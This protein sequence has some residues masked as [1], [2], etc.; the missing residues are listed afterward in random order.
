MAT[1][2]FYFA[3]AFGIIIFVAGAAQFVKYFKEKKYGLAVILFIVFT[4]IA[5]ALMLLAV[6]IGTLGALAG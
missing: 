5:S 3:I 2:A 6:S 1:F 4:I